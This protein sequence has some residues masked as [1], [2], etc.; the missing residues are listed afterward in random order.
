MSSRKKSKFP[1]VLTLFIYILTGFFIGFFCMDVLSLLDQGVLLGLAVLFLLIVGS[2]YLCII[3]HEGGHLVFGLISGYRFSSFRIGSLMLVHTEGKLQLKRHKIM[4][5]GGQCL[6]TP[7]DM[8]DGK[9]PYRLYNAGGVIFNLIA[10]CVFAV[11]MVLLWEL[12]IARSV[13]GM[14]F[15]TNLCLA[16]TN[17]IPMTVGVVNNDGKNMLTLGKSPKAMR[18]LWI[19]LKINECTANGQRMKDM[20]KEWFTIPE[21]IDDAF[22]AS[23]ISFAEN[24]LLDMHDLDG[25]LE[26]INKYLD[27]AELP[28]LY[29]I[30]FKIDKI[31]VLALKGDEGVEVPALFSKDVINLMKNMRAFPPVLRTQYAFALLL[32]EDKT[33]AEQILARFEKL[34]RVHP[35][36]CEIENERE[37]I[38]LVNEKEKENT[39][40]HS[41]AT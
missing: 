25:A 29:K 10:A 39:I 33:G 18:G 17:G 1:L 23:L 12:D 36:S 6:L 20:P 28:D 21:E 26:I 38:A 35:Y 19:Q 24:R 13:F 7:P 11:P 32:Q 9:I 37:L 31:Y 41:Q 30:L 27:C 2:F 3:L 15:A 4:G 16:L 8:K 34:A 14:L 22:S 5:T 40:C